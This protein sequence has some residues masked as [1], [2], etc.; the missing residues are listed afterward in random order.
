[1]SNRAIAQVHI[2]KFFTVVKSPQKKAQATVLYD[3]KVLYETV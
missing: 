2:A 3:R 1:M